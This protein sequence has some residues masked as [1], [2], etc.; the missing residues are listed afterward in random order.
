MQLK[1]SNHALEEELRKSH[2]QAAC[3]GPVLSGK[4]VAMGT[5]VTTSTAAGRPAPGTQKSMASKSVEDAA[6]EREMETLVVEV[7]SLREQLRLAR[8]KLKD[9]RA[10]AMSAQQ[11][12]ASIGQIQTPAAEDIRRKVLEFDQSAGNQQ[13]T[14]LAHG[15]ATNQIQHIATTVIKMVE[16]QALSGSDA[17]QA[18]ADEAH[19]VQLKTIQRQQ[20]DLE[21]MRDAVDQQQGKIGRLSKEVSSRQGMD[22]TSQHAEARRMLEERVRAT[23]RQ[24]GELSRRLEASEGSSRQFWLRPLR[25]HSSGIFPWR[26]A[27]V[28]ALHNCLPPTITSAPLCAACSRIWPHLFP[29]FC[30]MPRQHGNPKQVA[31]L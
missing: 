15:L 10:A 28:S 21:R 20:R 29:C 26:H 22:D 9:A 1:D 17:S 8:E 16:S 4:P 31:D 13:M 27:A 24:F 12:A 7:S 14:A 5:K 2:N 25:Y 19:V 18:S 23:E 6:A 11:S 30:A 3:T